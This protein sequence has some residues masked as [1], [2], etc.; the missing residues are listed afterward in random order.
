MVSMWLT[1]KW[2]Q[3]MVGCPLLVTLTWSVLSCLVLLSIFIFWAQILYD[4]FMMSSWWLHDDFRM[5]SWRLQQILFLGLLKIWL[6]FHLQYYFH[7]SF[8]LYFGKRGCLHNPESS[9]LQ[10]PPSY[11]HN[12]Y[13]ALAEVAIWDRIMT[14]WHTILDCRNRLMIAELLQAKLMKAKLSHGRGLVP[15]LISGGW[16]IVDPHK[17]WVQ[18]IT[19]AAVLGVRSVGRNELSWG[20]MRKRAGLNRV[21]PDLSSSH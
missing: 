5:T 1:Y 17:T 9:Q 6:L 20:I 18:L 21:P 2:G 16:R 10:L 19:V 13:A 4:D 3:K 15:R 12:V 11:L 8:S 14:T 7:S